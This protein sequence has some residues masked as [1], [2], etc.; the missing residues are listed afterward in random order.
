MIQDD[1]SLT[2]VKKK[3]K[4]GQEQAGDACSRAPRPP[5]P[6][7]GSRSSTAAA[8]RARHRTTL[9]WL[10]NEEGVTQVEQRGQRP[11]RSSPKTTL[12]YA[13]DQADQ[14][15]KLADMMGLPASALKPGTKN[16][17]GLT[18]DDAHPGQGLQGGRGARSPRPTKA[19][20]G[21]PEDRGG[22]DSVRQVTPDTGSRGAS[23]PEVTR[24][25]RTDRV[26]R[27]GRGRRP[28]AAAT[29]RGRRA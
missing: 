21:R 16:A 20:D 14:A 4:D 12:E 7:S 9:T 28:R 19:P 15:R 3:E 22:Q 2:E 26:R 1:V 13:P 11:A 23:A 6:T 17:A 5:R 25:D 18:A 29:G 27:T 24:S 8:R 10:Q